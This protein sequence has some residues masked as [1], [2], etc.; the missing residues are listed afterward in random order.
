MQPLSELLTACLAVPRWVDDVLSRGPFTTAHELIDAAQAAFP[1]SQ[2]EVSLATADHP[3][4]GQKHAGEG[5]AAEFSDAEQSSSPEE[6]AEVMAELASLNQAYYEKF[7]TVFLI[8]AT[9]RSKH[10]ILEALRV[11]I[12]LDHEAEALNRAREL[13]EIT[14][15]RVT[16]IAKETLS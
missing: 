2:A 15:L 12:M 13:E 1:L 16:A 5:K 3:A 6:P 11:R 9:G 14:I 7:G 8:R 10:Q 4:I